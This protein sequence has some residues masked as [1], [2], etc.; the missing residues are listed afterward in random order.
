MAQGLSIPSLGIGGMPDLGVQFSDA[1][2]QQKTAMEKVGTATTQREAALAPVEKKIADA[3]TSAPQ[4]PQY[5]Q[6]PDK[7]Q[8]MGMDD[9]QMTEAMSTMLALSAIGGLMTRTP[10]TAALNSFSAGMQGLMKGDHE[11]FQRESKTF[12]HNM[13]QAIAKN[14]QAA[15]EYKD[16]WEKHKLDITTL[17]SEWNMISKKYGDT[18]A[19]A[20]I[21]AKNASDV[22]KHVENLVRMAEQGEKTRKMFEMQTRQLDERQRHNEAQEALGRSRNDTALKRI[23]ASKKTGGGIGLKGKQ[24]DSYIN[25][26]SNIEAIQDII[27]ELQ[28]NPDAV[29]FKQFVPGVVLNRVDPDGTPVRASIANINSMTIKDRAGT[30]QT[31]QEMKNIAPFIPRDGDNADTMITKLTRMERELK[32]HNDTAFKAVGAGGAPAADAGGAS[33]YPDAEKEKRY[34]EWKAQ[35]GGEGG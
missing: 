17:Q 13:K 27:K 31:V 26:T 4:A 7:F 25:N 32:R 6:V 30:A 23:E 21:E 14:Q 3:G 20:N 22:M 35:Q 19:G 12:D 15:A 1:Q 11:L 24:L 29:G 16:A 9:K 10:M 34:Q 18:V 2:K 5:D 28:E 8:H 33:P